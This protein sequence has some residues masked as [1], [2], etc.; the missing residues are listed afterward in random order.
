MGEQDIKSKT[1]RL[2]GEKKKKTTPVIQKKEGGIRSNTHPHSQAALFALANLVGR[3]AGIELKKEGQPNPRGGG[4]ETAK[5]AKPGSQEQSGE[6]ELT[7]DWFNGTGNTG[8]IFQCEKRGNQK[9]RATSTR[10]GRKR[11]N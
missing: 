3:Q 2:M 6:G 10:R 8:K 11:K 9:K 5:T 1:R 4:G 7:P